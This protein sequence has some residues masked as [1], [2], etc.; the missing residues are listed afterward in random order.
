MEFSTDP[1]NSKSLKS[2]SLKGMST[3]GL[4][5]KI[6]SNWGY[7]YKKSMTSSKSTAAIQILLSSTNENLVLQF[8]C[9]QVVVGYWDFSQLIANKNTKSRFWD[10]NSFQVGIGISFEL[11]V[12]LGTRNSTV[13][14][15]ESEPKSGDNWNPWSMLG[16]RNHPDWLYVK[17]M[18]TFGKNWNF[19]PLTEPLR[20]QHVYSK[21]GTI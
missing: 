11:A 9:S 17:C 21:S 5:K 3:P 19:S 16:K 7:F 4:N 10:R 20:T 6:H 12:I 8:K 2:D 13:W 18:K 14:L 1:P 15:I